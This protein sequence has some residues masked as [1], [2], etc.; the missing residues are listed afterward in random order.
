MSRRNK[1][2][3]HIEGMKDFLRD[4]GVA[5]R[6]WAVAEKVFLA[7]AATTV[8]Q[9]ARDIAKSEGRLAIKSSRDV[10]TGGLGV[11]VYGGQGYS[12]GAE[13]G[14]LQ[15]KQFEMW[16]GNRDDAGYFLWPAIREFRDEE[17]LNLWAKEVWM[18]IKPAFPD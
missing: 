14:A 5:E 8:V 9:R 6:H 13:F 12:M 10:R 17:M 18:A 2:Y 3:A 15:Y 1:S 7:T 11:V 16:R 4:L